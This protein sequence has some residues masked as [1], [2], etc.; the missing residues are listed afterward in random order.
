M[1]VRATPEL[2]PAVREV[3]LTP[4][5]DGVARMR[6]RTARGTVEGMLHEAPEAA[7]GVILVGGVG[8]GFNGPANLYPEL[9]ET[10]RRQGITALRLDY[11]HAT[12]LT[13]SIHDVL[14]AIEALDRR[15]V[16]RVAL[17]GWSFGGAVVISAGALSDRVAGVATVASQSYGT[18]LAPALAPRPLLLLHGTGDQTLMP[19]CSQEIFYRA[20]E[21]KEI[22]LYPGANHGLDQVR[23]QMEARLREWLRKTLEEPGGNHARG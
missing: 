14:A 11:R 23:D 12:S 20:R 19:A 3:D 4:E 16:E 8:G 22:E 21:P 10:L 7:R 13:A 15:G 6:I 17:V 5:R 18:D 1:R 9:A 2:E